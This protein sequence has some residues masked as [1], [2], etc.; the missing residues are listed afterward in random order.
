M[1]KIEIIEC[2]KSKF[3]RSGIKVD[4]DENN[5]TIDDLLRL[6]EMSGLDLIVINPDVVTVISKNQLDRLYKKNMALKAI[7]K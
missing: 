1:T 6:I 3:L 7:D 5:I 4:V 2:I